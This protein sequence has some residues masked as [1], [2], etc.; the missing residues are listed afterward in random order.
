MKL[1]LLF[2]SAAIVWSQDPQS[3][4]KAYLNNIGKKYLTARAEEIGRIKTRAE[5]E[6]RQQ[7]VREKLLRLIGGLPS[8]H[9]PLNA[10][11]VGVI[12]HDDYRIEKIVY[13]SLPGFYVTANVYAPASGAGPYPG[14]LM[15]AGHWDGGKEGER[16]V[17]IGLARKGFIVLKPDPLG[18]GERLQY[19]D[20]DL[21]RSRIGIG[22][23]EH[24]H[25]NGHTMLIGDKIGRASCRERV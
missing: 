5:A 2:F 14:I 3:E 10:R 25:A 21:R 9:G 8:V 12:R 22:T 7:V 23:S 13:E 18:Q 15:P 19:Y 1:A 24:S 20:P 4:L 6:K 11:S 17:A 16:D